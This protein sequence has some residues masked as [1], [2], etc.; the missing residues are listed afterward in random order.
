M[1]V[2]ESEPPAAARQSVLWML[3][4]TIVTGLAGYLVMWLTART[5]GAAEYAVFGV[6]WSALFLVVGVL[7][8]LQ[9]EATRVVVAGD[10]KVAADGRPHSSL[11]VFAAAAGLVVV[12]VLLAT[13]VLW[14][15]PSLGEHAMLAVQV[16]IGSGLSAI[17][18]AASGMLAGRQRW[19]ILG[20]VI[21]ADGL[22]RLLCV[23]LVL[24]TLPDAAPLAWA[25]VAPYVLVVGGLFAIGGRRFIRAGRVALPYRRLISNSAQTVV[26][27]SATAVLING[28]PLVLSLV[29]RELDAAVLGALIFAITLTRAPLLVPLMALQSYLV[30]AFTLRRNDERKLLV[31]W[32][33]IVVAG[34]AAVAALVWF[35]GEW[36]LDVFVG[37][38]YALSGAL[39]A[40]LVLSAGCIGALCVSGPSVLARGLH[41]AYAIGWVVASAC[42]VVVLF[43][44]GPYEVMIPVAL[45]AGPVVGVA[46]HLGALVWARAQARRGAAE[47]SATSATPTSSAN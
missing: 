26:A 10:A 46:I 40:A 36:A 29:A 37:D 24:L 5:V 47:T 27:A 21:A 13:A 7:F 19:R 25:V 31:T 11:W 33:G 1:G 39:L 20:V 6:F 9:Q 32:L 18:A 28:F 16:A 35:A 34:A 15:P 12:V 3:G 2:G 38:E 42:T 22:L 17:V 30:T 44:P 8:G 14:A 41:A 4:G 43:I 23:G 45:A